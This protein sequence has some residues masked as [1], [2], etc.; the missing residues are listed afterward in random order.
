MRAGAGETVFCESYEHYHLFP[1]IAP[2]HNCTQ[3]QFFRSFAD[4]VVVLVEEAVEE[5]AVMRQRFV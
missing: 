2:S 5:F 1:R 4:V 3:F